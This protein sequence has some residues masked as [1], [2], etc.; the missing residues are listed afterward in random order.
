MKVSKI[1]KIIF[2][3][4]VLFLSFPNFTHAQ[5]SSIDELKDKVASRVAQLKL[6]EKRGIIGT[7]NEVKSNQITI[8]DIKNNTRIIDVDE[9]T[10]FS[11]DENGSFDFSNIKKGTIISALGIYNKESEKLLARYINEIEIPL[12]INGIITNK[13]DKNF[14]ITLSTEDQ[15]PYLI[16]I[17]RISKI[18]AYSDGKLTTYGFSK[19]NTME[20]AAVVG[21]PDPKQKNRITAS[22]I[23]TF[24]GTPKNPKIELSKISPSTS[25][26]ISPTKKNDK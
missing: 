17:E 21:F 22:K 19:I 5:E 26:S 13:D 24:P 10:K 23:V 3:I 12:F 4:I 8:S 18:Y 16:D 14:T 9:L 15:T 2:I 25:V 6:V 20:N 7:V 11:S 1:K